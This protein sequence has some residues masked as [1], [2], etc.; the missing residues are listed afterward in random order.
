MED[1]NDGNA[2][3]AEEVGG[4]GGEEA[5]LNQSDDL[6]NQSSGCACDSDIKACIEKIIFIFEEAEFEVGIAGATFDLA[7]TAKADSID[8]NL[9]AKKNGQG[10]EVG[11]IHSVSFRWGDF[12]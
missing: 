11:G 10:D 12:S 6:E 7:N 8:C 1:F 4:V 9:Q 2:G 3:N 5:G